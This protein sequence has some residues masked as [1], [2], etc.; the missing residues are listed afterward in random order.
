M[1]VKVKNRI[2]DVKRGGNSEADVCYNEMRFM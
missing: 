2:R 1:K